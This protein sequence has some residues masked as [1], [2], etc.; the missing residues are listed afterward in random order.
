MWFPTLCDAFLLVKWTGWTEI[1]FSLS[2]RYLC[3]VTA[4]L[5]RMFLFFS[6]FK[7]AVVL[8]MLI[9][10]RGRSLILRVVL[11]SFML[12]SLNRCM[13]I[14]AFILL[15]SSKSWFIISIYLFS[16][17]SWWRFAL[18]TA[19][20]SIK[21]L[22]W[23]FMSFIPELLTLSAYAFLERVIFLAYT[24]VFTAISFYSLTEILFGMTCCS[25]GPSSLCS[26][27]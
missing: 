20:V 2:Y 4:T 5:P 22:I 11:P 1:Y 21:L 24:Y 18:M 7:F 8:L 25:R 16:F 6:H 15:E 13:F 27:L 23:L 17:I 3:L 19:V 9:M 10:V 12:L 14:L 26:R